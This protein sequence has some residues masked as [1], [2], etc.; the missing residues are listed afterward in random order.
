MTTTPR[1]QYTQQQQQQNVSDVI[2]KYVFTEE[3][4]HK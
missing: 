4:G 2:E 1:S 3:Y